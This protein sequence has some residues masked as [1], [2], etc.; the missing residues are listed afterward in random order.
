MCCKHRPHGGDGA[1]PIGLADPMSPRPR[2]P[3]VW[4]QGPGAGR[5]PGLGRGGLHLWGGS[6]TP[7][8]SRSQGMGRPHS[9]PPKFLLTLLPRCSI[10][11]QRGAG[12]KSSLSPARYREHPKPNP[13]R[14]GGGGH[15]LGGGIFWGYGWEPSAAPSHPWVP[16]SHPCPVAPPDGPRGCFGAPPAPSPRRGHKW[17][18]RR[19]IPPGT[20]PVSTG[21][22]PGTPQ[23]HPPLLF[24]MRL[25]PPT[26]ASR[27]HAYSTG[28]TTAAEYRAAHNEEA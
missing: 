28:C 19:Q 1:A 16:T 3:W 8:A 21:H 14:G 13:T 22:R 11:M 2:V 24:G 6:F 27:A 10:P 4:G 9:G 5:R 20:S 25:W 7:G 26:H 17:G 18:R 15:F 23:K 12:T